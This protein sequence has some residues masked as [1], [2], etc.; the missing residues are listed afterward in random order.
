MYVF[1]DT[2]RDS[3]LFLCTF[4]FLNF[5]FWWIIVADEQEYQQ[6][7]RQYKRAEENNSDIST[8]ADSSILPSKLTDNKLI[9][10]GLS[11]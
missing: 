10:A 4:H 2:L 1:V 8:K 11:T 9:V 3:C 6:E 7:R 5:Y